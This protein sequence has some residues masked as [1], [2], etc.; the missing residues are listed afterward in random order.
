M[1]REFEGRVVIFLSPE[2]LVNV[3]RMILGGDFID[4][5]IVGKEVVD[6]IIEESSH[7][8][9][10]LGDP[11]EPLRTEI[12]F[13]PDPELAGKRHVVHIDPEGRS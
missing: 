10:V 1:S 5:Y 8:P 11:G 4:R 13:K 3:K 2:N 6:A 12:E 9:G 7:L